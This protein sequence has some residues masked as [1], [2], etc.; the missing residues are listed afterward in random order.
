MV[1]VLN[2]LV[3]LNWSLN[4]HSKQLKPTWLWLWIWKLIQ[5]HRVRNELLR[6]LLSSHAWVKSEVFQLV[7]NF[8]PLQKNLLNSSLPF[9]L[10][11]FKHIS[12]EFLTREDVMWKKLK[13]ELIFQVFKNSPEIRGML[14]SG[15][16]SKLT[17]FLHLL[18]TKINIL[19]TTLSDVP[20]DKFSW[21]QPQAAYPKC[22]VGETFLRSPLECLTYKKFFCSRRDARE[23]SNELINGQYVGQ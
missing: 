12:N 8:Q 7:I 1:S 15:P 21:K 9:D 20:L 22:S 3:L 16:N 23:F 18:D 5:T 11:V 13:P 6:F 10:A 17:A 4:C 19:K 14:S 2:L